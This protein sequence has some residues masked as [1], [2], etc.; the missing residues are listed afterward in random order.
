MFASAECSELEPPSGSV[1]W[2]EPGCSTDGDRTEAGT[3]RFV[4]IVDD[5]PD[6]LDVTSFV[7]ENEGMA[8]ET[9]KNGAEALALLRGGRLPRLVLLDLMMPV[10]N[11][12]EFLD[13]VAKDPSLKVIPIVV[14]TAA[15]HSQVPGAMDV[16]CKP[17]DLKALL[18]VVEH[19]VRGDCDGGA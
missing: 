9:A 4:L 12:W 2:V 17:M 14:L 18:R 13:E 5:D 15:D 11:G 10:M 16:L 7:I 8:V 19:Y 3:S 6:L 1:A